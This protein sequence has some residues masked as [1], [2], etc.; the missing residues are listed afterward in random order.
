MTGFPTW[1]C[2]T[3]SVSPASYTCAGLPTVSPLVCPECSQEG[4]CNCRIREIEQ[5]LRNYSDRSLNSYCYGPENSQEECTS[6]SSSP[7]ENSGIWIHLKSES[8]G[9]LRH[10]ESESSG[11]W[12][13]T[14]STESRCEEIPI[15]QT[16]P[17]RWSCSQLERGYSEEGVFW[18][19]SRSVSPSSSG[20]FSPPPPQQEVTC[21]SSVFSPPP[22]RENFQSNGE[23]YR[24]CVKYD[25]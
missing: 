11:M 24:A 9:N 19:S 14:Y 18:N 1:G 3:N 10:S 23:Y 20:I 4:Y 16:C 21:C 25:R 7:Q 2:T 8:S 5:K 22:P 17:T 6:Y 12:S 15:S 13:R